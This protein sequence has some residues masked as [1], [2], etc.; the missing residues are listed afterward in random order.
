MQTKTVGMKA[1]FPEFDLHV[2][3]S[4]NQFHCHTAAT[5]YVHACRLLNQNVVAFVNNRARRV[6]NRNIQA[7]RI[8]QRAVPSNEA[9]RER[10][11][12]D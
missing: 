1:A 3:L 12:F 10:R 8:V 5:H 7:R 11:E 4:E 2:F 6:V 9:F